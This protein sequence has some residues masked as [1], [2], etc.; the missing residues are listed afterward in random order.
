MTSLLPSAQAKR[1]DQ[2]LERARSL[3]DHF[4]DVIPRDGMVSLQNR[5]TMYV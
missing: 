3:R 2:D 4:R 1:G 5:I